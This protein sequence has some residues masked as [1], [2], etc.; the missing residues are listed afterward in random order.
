VVPPPRW[1]RPSARLGRW[2]CI[3]GFTLSARG[4]WAAYFDG[5]YV[6]L[7]TPGVDEEAS[8]TLIDER[9]GTKTTVA[10]PGCYLPEFNPRS[11]LGGPWL[12]LNCD[13][14]EFEL[15]NLYT[16]EWKAVDPDP[17]SFSYEN[18]CGDGMPP[19]SGVIVAGFGADW[20]EWVHFTRVCRGTYHF[21]NIDTGQVQ[22]LPGWRAGGRIVPDL[23]SP[24]LV[25]TLCLP[26]KVPPAPT[27]YTNLDLPPGPG[28]LSM[29]GS[30]AIVSSDVLERCGS[31][32]KR[33]VGN[34]E[35]L[36]ASSRAIVWV[37]GSDSRRL[38][39]LFLP[40]LRRFVI[41]TGPS[42]TPYAVVLSSGELYVIDESGRVFATPA[43]TQRDRPT[44]ATRH[45]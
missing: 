13:L 17:G 42:I 31:R 41:A 37:A 39:G 1:A 26:L 21:Q 35:P 18:D 3:P 10:Y 19:Y 6:L 9:T 7:Q 16:G 29:Y 45:N 23:D 14:G 27:P 40:S 5:P 32:L 25:R 36:G 33:V 24:S 44:P 20:I 12:M 4:P 15:Y 28:S 8:G 43:P 38:D 30:F 11:P 2:C 22:S 34:Q